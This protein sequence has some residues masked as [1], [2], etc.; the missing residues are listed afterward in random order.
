MLIVTSQELRMA[1]SKGGRHKGEPNLTHKAR[2]MIG[3]T[4]NLTTA[5]KTADLFSISQNHAHELKHAK[6]DNHQGVIPELKNSIDATLDKVEEKCADLVLGTLDAIT[7]ADVKPLALEKKT[8]IAVNITNVLSK[9]SSRREE[10]K[11]QAATVIFYSPK[12]REVKNY[13][14][15]EVV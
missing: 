8:R 12:Q 3:A 14:I 4:A 5:K 9:I 15:I 7:L 6:H 11:V 1:L 10:K 2:T 13:D